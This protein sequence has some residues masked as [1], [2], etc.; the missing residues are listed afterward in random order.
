[1]LVPIPKSYCCPCSSNSC[2]SIHSE[3]I[4]RGEILRLTGLWE[5]YR[6]WPGMEG[7]ASAERMS[8]ARRAGGSWLKAR[9]SALLYASPQAQPKSWG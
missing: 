7:D 3:R 1:M 5:Q 6:G 9:G 8:A 2:L 4:I